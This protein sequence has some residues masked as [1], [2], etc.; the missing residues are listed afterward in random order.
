MASWSLK[1][2]DHSRFGKRQH[3]VPM[4]RTP[5]L[6]RVYG[7]S[8]SLFAGKTALVQGMVSCY[9]RLS[10]TIALKLLELKYEPTAERTCCRISTLGR[11]VVH[12]EAPMARGV[13]S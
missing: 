7:G 9:R 6:R 10:S 3:F 1:N 2:C 13:T 12:Y 11:K 5:V 8:C 4:H